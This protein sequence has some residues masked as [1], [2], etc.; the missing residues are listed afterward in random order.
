MRVKRGVKTGALV[1]VLLLALAGCGATAAVKGLFVS[2]VSLEQVGEQFVNISEQITK[3][4]EVSAI[5][6]T[7]CDKYRAFGLHFKKTYPLAVGMWE[8]SR[9]ANDKATQEKA[10]N[11]VRSLASDMSKLASEALGAFAPE[12]K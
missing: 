11:V 1:L 9:K 3:G 12:M 8:A 5:P 4:C 10:E 2:G 6:Q 7:T